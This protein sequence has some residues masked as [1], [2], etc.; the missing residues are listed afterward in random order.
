MRLLELCC[1]ENHSWS[2][3]G[4][5][6]GFQCT[7]LD[8]ESKCQADL[9]MDVRH[10]WPEGNGH[11]DIVCASPD[12]AELSQ[13]RRAH[14]CKEGD[15]SFADSV[16]QACVSIIQHYVTR[17]GIGLLEN[18]EQA[19]PKRP[20][21]R[22]YDHLGRVVDYCMWSSPRPADFDGSR[23]C[24]Q[25]LCDWFPARKPTALY[26]FGGPTKWL[27]SRARCRRLKGDCG[28]CDENGA[29]ISWSRHCQDRKQIEVCRARGFPHVFSTAELHRIPS[30][31]CRELLQHAAASPARG[32]G[33]KERDAGVPR[34]QGDAAA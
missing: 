32:L 4:R 29:H 19:L 7:T 2:K 12:C 22:N 6:L 11:F 31:L 15:E 33:E 1:G 20:W 16:G 23:P 30:A 34:M 26:M 21:M 17:G 28:F 9:R 10:F 3:A 8:W 13:A 5:A 27:P 24:Q 14:G 18:P 25:K